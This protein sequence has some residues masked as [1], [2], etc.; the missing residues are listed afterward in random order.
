MH[1]GGKMELIITTS[2]FSFIIIFITVFQMIRVYGIAYKRAELTTQKYIF[3]TIITSVTGVI[4]ASMLP[5][6]YQI[7]FDFIL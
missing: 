1:K 3:L 7:L 6:V 4:I 2:I 5:V